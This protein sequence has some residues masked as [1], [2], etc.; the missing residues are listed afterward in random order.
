[1]NRAI[2]PLWCGILVCSAASVFAFDGEV[3]S[4]DLE[5]ALSLLPEV[6]HWEVDRDGHLV[7]LEGRLTPDGPA[8][9]VRVAAAFIDIHRNL[10]G[11]ATGS[12]F[13]AESVWRA[14]DRSIVMLRQS[15][16]G[17]AATAER[18]ELVLSGSVLESVGGVVLDDR[19]VPAAVD[20][21][22]PRFKA[23]AVARSLLGPT[24]SEEHNTASRILFGSAHRPCWRVETVASS[25]VGSVLQVV[26]VDALNGDVLEHEVQALS[27]PSGRGGGGRD[28]ASSVDGCVPVTP[29]VGEFSTVE[30]HGLWSGADQGCGR[31]Q[32]DDRRSASLFHGNCLEYWCDPFPSTDQCDHGEIRRDGLVFGQGFDRVKIRFL[33][34]DRE[35][36][37]RLRWGPGDNQ[38]VPF[39]VRPGVYGV[40]TVDLEL[41]HYESWDSAKVDSLTLEMV[42]DHLVWIRS[43]DLWPGP[44]LEF[45]AGPEVETEPPGGELIEGEMVTVLQDVRNAGCLLELNAHA[46]MR[47]VEYALH[48]G[49]GSGREETDVVC[50]E[51]QIPGR[52][53]PESE[54]E[55]LPICAFR[56]PGPGVWGLEARFVSHPSPPATSLL[57]VESAVHPDLAIDLGSPVDLY[58][59]NLGAWP[60]RSDVLDR[61]RYH[62]PDPPCDL[63]WVI[64][65]GVSAEGLDTPVESRIDAWGRPTSPVAN[66]DGCDPAS[67][68]W[69]RI[70]L[71][72]TATMGI[73]STVIE[74]PLHRALLEA[75][76]LGVDGWSLLDLKLQVEPAD[77]ETDLADNVVCLPS[78]IPVADGALDD[79]MGPTWVDDDYFLGPEHWPPHGLAWTGVT[80]VHEGGAPYYDPD[81]ALAV[82]TVEDGGNEVPRL[83]WFEEH[84]GESVSGAL[85]RYRRSDPGFGGDP[86]LDAGAEEADGTPGFQL[87]ISGHPNRSWLAAD[88][89]WRTLVWRRGNSGPFGDDPVPVLATPGSSGDTLSMHLAPDTNCLLDEPGCPSGLH[90][91]TTIDVVGVWRELG[92]PP[93]TPVYAVEG[94]RMLQ[95][96]QW[97]PPPAE[98]A[99]G[100]PL[101]FAVEVRNIGSVPGTAVLSAE[102]DILA[103]NENPSDHSMTGAAT[104]TIAPGASYFLL[105][106]P[107]WTP[108]ATGPFRVS[109]PVRESGQWIGSVSSSIE[110]VG[111]PTACP[112]PTVNLP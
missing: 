72:V 36:F 11:A 2:R 55:D 18:V 77:G 99:V 7:A 109:G 91:T 112:V 35:V 80:V 89:Q 69:F 86:F 9:A 54:V 41:G 66:P 81:R 68:G 12:S 29:P 3:G 49:S 53:F 101:D 50:S 88:S 102:I 79:A 75:L 24:M 15:V 57:E 5:T 95:D 65:M 96:G 60:C 10:F 61:G 64:T 4:R 20:G 14:E 48:Q 103:L 62:D 90:P 23:M 31:W 110:V 13:E 34:P 97:L 108:L 42:D 100:Q 59:G 44:W 76:P 87:D 39:L 73:G 33:V 6:T 43:L 70:A 19:D 107:P 46:D 21:T 74:I 22:M 8:P 56:L 32:F 78:W 98:V 16:D 92:A 84:P 106:D 26:V 83:V 17:F 105:L 38:A 85:I 1:M 27:V 94:L 30:G 47:A 111:D 67:Q 45:A 63:P 28:G 82:V 52:I 40:V 104:V 51:A 37:M 71:P 93:P 25:S 58:S